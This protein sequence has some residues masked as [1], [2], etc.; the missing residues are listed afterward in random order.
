MP[1]LFYEHRLH[2]GDCNV[3]S[4]TKFLLVWHLDIRS[5]A[6]PVGGTEDFNCLFYRHNLFIIQPQF[7]ITPHHVDNGLFLLCLIVDVTYHFNVIE[8]VLLQFI[9]L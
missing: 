5:P 7:L 1:R 6:P 2:N 3:Y 8:K 9:N 4:L